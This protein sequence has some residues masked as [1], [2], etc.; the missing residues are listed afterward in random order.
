[1][2]SKCVI[3]KERKKEKKTTHVVQPGLASFDR[4][5][6]GSWVVPSGTIELV[7]DL[8]RDRNLPAGLDFFSL[9][10]EETN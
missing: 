10:D 4:I 1:M 3:E 9:C 7:L 8:Y 5:E 6:T 2:D